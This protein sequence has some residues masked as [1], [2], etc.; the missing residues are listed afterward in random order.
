[1]GLF[2]GVAVAIV[3]A[4]FAVTG[5]PIALRWARD[6]WREVGTAG[7]AAAIALAWVAAVGWTGW[8]PADTLQWYYAGLGGQLERAG[9]VPTSV[10]EW[11]QSVRWLP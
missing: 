2:S 4:A 8:P 9:G 3:A 7:W 11:G 10:A 6:S 1:M 5:L